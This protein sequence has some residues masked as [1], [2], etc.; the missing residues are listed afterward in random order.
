MKK[1]D[2]FSEWF[3]STLFNAEVMD[4]RY[5][6]KGFSV[7]K[8][9]GARIA[10]KI[11]G[12]LED[13]LEATG[14][15]P[16]FFPVVI[17]EDAFAKEAKVILRA[18]T[19]WSKRAN[20]VKMPLWLIKPRYK[21]SRA[22]EEVE[23]PEP[24]EEEVIEKSSAIEYVYKAITQEVRAKAKDEKAKA[25]GPDGKLNKAGAA[26]AREKFTPLIN[27]KEL[28]SNIFAEWEDEHVVIALNALG[29]KDLAKLVQGSDDSADF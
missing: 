28:P 25:F 16:A 18:D 13:R 10:R 8:P 20:K 24:E 7:Y 19:I 26:I 27:E 3:D 17:S 2:N 4:N 9:W 5:P 14:H 22:Y 23:T 1:F 21:D 6:I 29:Y 11:T 12:I 15:D